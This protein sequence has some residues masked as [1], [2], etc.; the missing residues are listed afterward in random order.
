MTCGIYMIVNKETKQKYIGQ[1]INIERRWGQHKRGTNYNT[2]YI[3]KAIK[4]HGVDNFDYIII[5]EVPRNKL[6]ER[7]KYWINFYN[8]FRDPN[9][10]NLLIGGDGFGEKENHPLYGTKNPKHSKRMSGKNN[11]N[12]GKRWKNPEQ[13]KR[14]SG[15]NNPNYGKKWTSDFRKKNQE[16]WDNGGRELLSKKN[17]GINN[18]F[19]GKH[20]TPEAIEKIKRNQTLL[21]GED[22]PHFKKENNTKYLEIRKGVNKSTKQ[23]FSY[24][25]IE[26]H[27]RI[28]KSQ[29]LDN[30]VEWCLNN[31]KKLTNRG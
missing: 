20:H 19:Y 27:K 24:Y 3:D 31:N 21:Y 12:Y 7:E 30:L 26:N 4:K 29:N 6:N 1:S 23:G 5:E 22:N 17:Q 9:H 8:T 15:K 16:Y 25:Y 2:Q 10:Y 18:P 11:P 28:K 13:S 14:M